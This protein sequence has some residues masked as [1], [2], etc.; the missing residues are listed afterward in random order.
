MFLKAVQE[1][2]VEG[3]NYLGNLYYKQKKYDKANI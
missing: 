3:M 1:G 2:N